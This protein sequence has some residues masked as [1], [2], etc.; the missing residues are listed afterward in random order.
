[1]L[2]HRHL[3]RLRVWRKFAR[4]P[5]FTTAD[6]GPNFLRRA[7]GIREVLTNLLHM[8][9]VL[10][11]LLSTALVVSWSFAA[12][13]KS[14]DQPGTSVHGVLA[15]VAET[16]VNVLHRE[17]RT[18]TGANVRLPQG[19]DK[20]IAVRVPW[21]ADFAT[22]QAALESSALG[23]PKAG[24]TYYIEGT[25][26]LVHFADNHV[27]RIFADAFHGTGT[28]SLAAGRSVGGDPE[29]LVVVVLGYQQASWDWLA[30]QSWVDAA[31]ESTFDALGAAC[32]SALQVHAFSAAGHL[33]FVAAG[34]SFIDTTATS[35]GGSPWVVRVGGVEPDGRSSLPTNAQDPT[36]Y[37]A[38][39]YDV[40]GLFSNRMAQGTSSTGYV[41]GVGTSGSSPLVAGMTVRVLEHLRMALGDG[42]TGVR[43]GA[44]VRVG[45]G[46]RPPARGPLADGI[47]TADELRVALLRSAVPALPTPGIRYAAEGYGW[48]NQ[49]ASAS[50]MRVLLGQAAAPMR[51]RDDLVYSATR[52]ARAAAYASNGCST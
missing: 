29:A 43:D 38:R 9:R 5:P 13:A 12:T 51:T 48:F 1:M 44:L 32:D 6:V 3:G 2:R 39:T 33:A 50:L 34:N 8:R 37:S 22:Q 49:A 52:T 36:L 11:S 16:G 20:V 25:R 21:G 27:T 31:T 14:P 47:L 26:L 15:V 42:S 46:H 18:A 35:P 17:F 28:A 41:T 10:L 19:L 45:A 24:A 40:G 4:R 30:G 7:E 23:H